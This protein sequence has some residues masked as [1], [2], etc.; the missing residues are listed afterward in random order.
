M[1]GIFIGYRRE[2]SAGWAG[3]LSEQLKERFGGGVPLTLY[4]SSTYRKHCKQ[5]ASR[6]SGS[7]IASENFISR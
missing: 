5:R 1:N 4:C 3:R 2:D 6:S 7:W